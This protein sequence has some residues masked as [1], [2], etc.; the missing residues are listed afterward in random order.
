LLHAVGAVVRTM[1]NPV[2]AA[3]PTAAAV[4]DALQALCADFGVD[5]PPTPP[6]VAVVPAPE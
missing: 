6:S 2:A 4:W 5:I 1:T 3:R